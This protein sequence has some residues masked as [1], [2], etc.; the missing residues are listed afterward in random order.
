MTMRLVTPAVSAASIVAKLEFAMH[1]SAFNE[2]C[3]EMSN[4]HSL[5]IVDS[6][7]FFF[8]HLFPV[9]EGALTL[10]LK[11]GGR[12]VGG[13][14]VGCVKSSTGSVAFP[15]TEPI[16]A[17]YDVTA[18]AVSFLTNHQTYLSS[19]AFQVVQMSEKTN[20]LEVYDSLL[21]ANTTLLAVR[22]VSPTM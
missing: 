22:E 6:N 8:V 12:R 15:Q 18:P 11:E 19:E 3:F 16:S 17:V 13:S 14:R 2:T 10:Q 4:I 21:L 1:T 7:P 5:H 9:A 20:L